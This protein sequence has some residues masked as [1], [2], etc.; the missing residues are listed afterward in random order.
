M[1]AETPAPKV[2][3]KDIWFKKTGYEPHGGQR[4]VHYEPTRHRVLCNGRRWGKTLVGGKECETAALVKNFLGQ[5]QIGWI[6]GPEY[7]DCEKEF[8]VIY[9][10]FKS[11]GID[12]VSTRFLNNVENGNM[13][14]RT[15]WGFDLQCRSARHPE[16]LVGEGL[17][18]V[19]IVEAGRHKR[20]MWGD[21]VRPALSDKRGWSL[22]SGVPE[23]AAED[24]L[25]YSLFMRGQDPTKKSWWSIRMPSWTNTIVFPGGKNDP[26]ILEAKDDLTDDEFRRQYGAEFVERVGRVMAEWD[27]EVHIRDLEYNRRWPLYAA[28]DFGYTN[29]WVWL[30]IQVDVFGT[31]YVIGE[32]RFRLRDTEDIARRDLSIHPLLPQ[33]QMIYVDPAAPDDAAILARVLG[34]PTNN[35]TGGE[36]STRLQM[37]RSALKLRPEHLPDSHPDK[38]PRLFVDRSCHMLEWEMRQGYRWP[39]NKAYKSGEGRNP[40]EQPLDKDNH[41]P[42]ALGRFFKGHMAPIL[43]Q[44]QTRMS[45]YATRH[46]VNL[47][48][49]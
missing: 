21:Y 23:G 4:L 37:I 17:D 24:S 3:R 1:S 35:H 5:P 42:E 48:R 28:V 19:L 14:I 38:K 34:K 15:K 46:A 27:S 22:T 43:P 13:H 16:S 8:R 6:I 30:W 9:N 32:E 36:L 39:E 2:F 12:Q 11:L 25:L 40:S 44:G 18:F 45:R 33:V 29:D 20:R 10:T 49:R 47:I 7:T 41:G 31:V 26:E